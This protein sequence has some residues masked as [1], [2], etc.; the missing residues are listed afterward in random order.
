MPGDQNGLVGLIRRYPLAAFLLWLSTVGLA[1]GFIPVIAKAGWAI[2]LPLQ[3]FAI[4]ET[5]VG[6][7]LPAV[8]ITRIVDGSQGLRDLGR[9]AFRL[10]VPARW[11]AFSLLVLPLPALVLAIALFGLPD[12]TPSTLL[13]AVLAGLLLQ[14][15]ITFLTINFVEEIAWMGFF[16]AR[17]QPS[18]GPA[19]AAVL[20]AA[21]FTLMH[22]PLFVVNGT[23]LVVIV[24]LFFVM[25]I[26]FRALIG[27]VYNSTD[28]LF[29]VGVL[30]AAGN[31]A[32]GGSGLGEGLLPRLY[33]SSWV[34]VLHTLAAFVIGLALIAATRGRLGAPLGVQRAQAS[35][36][37]V[38]P[39]AV[40]A[41]S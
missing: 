21:G 19:L 38:E 41:R 7:L 23:P 13:V 15:A 40:G 10:R 5:V 28:S 4:A 31:A 24:P 14:G 39:S 11:Y 18:R 32:T 26:G 33:D 34:S 22:L 27:W 25:A 20:T 37:A 2:A 12:A 29:L 16:Q 36:H 17:L 35:D 6:A 8:V 30:H 1:I 3:P 9:H